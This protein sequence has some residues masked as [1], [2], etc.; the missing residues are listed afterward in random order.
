MSKSPDSLTRN[1]TMTKID[2]KTASTAVKDI[3]LA[4]PDGL[5]E[6]IRAVM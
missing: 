2:G 1:A 3:L 6:V 4:N 5:R